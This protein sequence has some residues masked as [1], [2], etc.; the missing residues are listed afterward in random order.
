MNFS[1]S[2]NGKSGNPMMPIDQ[3]ASG[4][5]KND[6][7]NVGQ[8]EWAL[9]GVFDKEINLLRKI[10]LLKQDLCHVED[11]SPLD[12]YK[13]MDDERFGGITAMK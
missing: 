4:N 3:L 6:S 9:V 13:F 12:A 1:D 10:E 5:Y 11:F 8:V 7:H 2:K